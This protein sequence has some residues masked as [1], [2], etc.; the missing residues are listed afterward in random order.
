LNRNFSRVSPV[1]R[2]KR[3]EITRVSIATTAV[4]AAGPN[5]TAAVSVKTSEIEKLTEIDGILS[6]AD[7]LITVSATSAHHWSGG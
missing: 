7:P 6:T 5:T 2:F 1:V 3:T 4:P